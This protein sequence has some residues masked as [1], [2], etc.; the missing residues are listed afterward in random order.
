MGHTS[1]KLVMHVTNSLGVTGGAEQQ[2]VSNLRRFRDRRLRHHLVCLYEEDYG[3]RAPDVPEDTAITYLYGPGVRAQSRL[4]TVRRL[5]S[6][7]RRLQPDLIHCSVAEASLASRLVGRKRRVPVVESLINLSHERVRLVDNPG[8]KAWKLRAHS[9]AD[10]ITTRWVRRFHALSPAVAESWQRVVGIDPAR[11][12]IIPRGVDAAD[13]ADRAHRG[14]DIRRELGVPRDAPLILAVGRQAAQ[15]G[16]RYLVAAMPAVLERF[17]AAHLVIAGQPGNMSSVLQEI[18]ADHHLG[19]SVHIV[20]ARDDVPALLAAADIFAYPSLFEG[21]G[22]G[23]LEAMAMGRACIT[24]NVA[25]LNGVVTD[26]T[27]GILVAPR[28]PA[29][30]A[31]AVSRL[32]AEPELAARLGAAAAAHVEAH[33]RLDEAAR[34]IEDL[35]VRTLGLNGS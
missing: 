19:A 18:V 5:N 9:L 8:V 4:Q 21:L 22:V 28:D 11:I 29:A 2:L 1:A 3:S 17:P 32:A 34:G 31:G 6:T 10:R 26:D 20:G 30:L 27:T 33:Y 24:T 13:L 7:V 12:S 14:G 15:K 16:Q 35:Y 23:L 25:P